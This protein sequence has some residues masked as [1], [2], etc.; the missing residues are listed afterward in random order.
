MV[1]QL[2]RA[3]YTPEPTRSTLHTLSPFDT[4]VVKVSKIH[5]SLSLLPPSLSLPDMVTKEP[6]GSVICPTVHG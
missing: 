4:P 6:R 1:C 2:L 3:G 5:F